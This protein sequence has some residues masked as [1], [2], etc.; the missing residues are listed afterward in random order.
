MSDAET[1]NPEENPRFTDKRRIDPETG[2]VREPTAP[3]GAEVDP[4]ADLDFETP[5]TAGELVPSHQ[6]EAA[7]ALAAERLDDLQRRNA[8]YF[9]LETQYSNYVKRSKADG[10]IQR[11]EGV[12]SV[13]EALIGVLDD[14]DLARQHGDL[15]G[16]FAS[17]AEKLEQTLQRF[18]IE[19]Y[20]AVGE[21]FDPNVHEALMHGHSPDVTEPTVQ[22]VLQPGYRV[23]DRIVRAVRVAVVDPEA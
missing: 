5:H 1:P 13:V 17:I 6:L 21:A 9:N 11:E 19:K 7:E 10:A 18:G 23:G 16:P 3:E 20:G 15:V 4:L 12:V 2:A 22:A 14:I 8:A